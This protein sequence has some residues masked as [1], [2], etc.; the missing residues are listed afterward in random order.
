[1]RLFLV[2]ADR[3]IGFDG[4]KGASIHLRSLARALARHGAEVVCLARKTAAATIGPNLTLRPFVGA[5]SILDAA[6]DF[7]PPDAIYERSSL[8]PS[9]AHAAARA[10]GVPRLLEVNAPLFDEASLHRPDTVG[11]NDREDE[12]ANWRAADLVFCV[13]SALVARVRA[14]RGATDGV[15]LAWNGCDPELFRAAPRPEK[16]AFI[17]FLG[18]PKP[19][20]GAVLLADVVAGLRAKGF[21]IR[22]RVIGG[23][24]G[25]EAVLDRA[26]ELGI[27]GFVDAT[28]DLEQ[29]DALRMLGR[30]TLSLAPYPPAEDFY[31]CPLKVV[32]SMAA[33]VPTIAADQGD[34]AAVLDDDS[35][36]VPPGDVQAMI[37]S[38]AGLLESEDRRRRIA[39]R[40]RSR[41]FAELTWDKVAADV[42]ECARA[43]GG[44][45]LRP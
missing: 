37:A 29:Q 12:E 43:V 40:G 41:A 10:L 16:P 35:L 3:G 8:G 13:S 2:S 33:G 38:A 7:G 6:T 15:R 28:G 20:H 18:R 4:S 42:L 45:R 36:L 30:A 1:M 19:W 14:A 21:D 34:I 44:G 31:F 24:P 32:E 26:L 9:E 17:A 27:G 25:A 5:R 23:G 22:G 11:P 39:E